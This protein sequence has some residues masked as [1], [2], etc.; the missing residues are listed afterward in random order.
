[1][2]KK[3]SKQIM[4]ISR[5]RNEFLKAKTDAN[6]KAYNKQRITM[7][8][9]F[10]EKRNPFS[11]IQIPKRLSIINV[12]GKLL[13]R[14]F[15]IK[16]ELKTKLHLLRVKLKFYLITTLQQK[17]LTI[18]LQILSH[19]YVCNVKMICQLVW[20]IFRTLWKRSLKKS[21]ST[22]VLLQ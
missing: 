1:M 16:I 11:V 10:A 8:L 4:T 19:R 5:L 3:L 18:N 12:S 9:F 21:N 13:S 6:R 14:S 15:Q 20:N 22:Q 7:Y 17:R 2:N